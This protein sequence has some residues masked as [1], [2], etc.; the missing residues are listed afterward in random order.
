MEVVLLVMVRSARGV[1]STSRRPPQT[2]TR[3]GWYRPKAY[4]FFPSSQAFADLDGPVALLEAPDPK[5]ILSSNERPIGKQ[6]LA[7]YAVARRERDQAPPRDQEPLASQTSTV[8]GAGFG[9]KRVNATG[10]R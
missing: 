7:G 8:S 5:R 3:R 1:P 10:P 2:T 9:S 4:T 6:G